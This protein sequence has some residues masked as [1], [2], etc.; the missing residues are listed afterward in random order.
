[1]KKLFFLGIGFAFLLLL[2]PETFASA[3]EENLSELRS[4]V[5]NSQTLCSSSKKRCVKAI[6]DQ[7]N[8]ADPQSSASIKE[9]I[10]EMKNGYTQTLENKITDLKN[11]VRTLE[12]SGKDVQSL[13]QTIQAAER[14][15]DSLKKL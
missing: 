1:M 15:L 7:I 6:D 14:K 5:Q 11:K 9:C 2:S 8:N 10:E 12:K 13:E 3:Q 4:K